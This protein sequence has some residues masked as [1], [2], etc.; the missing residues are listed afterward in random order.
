MEFKEYFPIYDKLTRDQQLRLSAAAALRTIAQ[1]TLIRAGSDDC[2]GL[3]LV[4][5]GQ[6]RAYIN[7]EDG[8]EITV[9]R[10]LERD[11]C[12]FSASCIMRGIQFDIY[13]SA[14]KDTR[15]WLIP[16]DVYRS[17]M[18]SSAAVANY[19][20]EVMAGRFSEVMWL[21]QQILWK[22]FDRRLATF[23][24]EEAQ[25]ADELQVT[26]EKIALHL[27][28]AREVVTRML[29]YFQDEGLVQLG[30]GRIRICDPDRLRRLAQ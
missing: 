23:L 10:L 29:K 28:T 4:T 5:S 27:G 21:L 18:D 6:L 25:D 15:A 26:H 19:T 12:L 16:A 9:Y 24:I 30:R 3:L 1:G 22:S 2:L 8:R 14:E 7:S 11:M 17:L 13:I 20:N